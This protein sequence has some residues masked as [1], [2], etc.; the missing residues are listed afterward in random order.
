[1]LSDPLELRTTGT[2]YL[3]WYKYLEGAPE[4]TFLSPFLEKYENL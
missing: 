2:R 4:S 1:M 3:W